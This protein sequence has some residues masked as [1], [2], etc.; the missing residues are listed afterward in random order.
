MPERTWFSMVIYADVLLFL[1]TVVTY[2]LL[3]SVCAVA[4]IHRRFWRLLL[5]SVAGGI[6]AFAVLLPDLGLF[7]VPFKFA[8]AAVIVLI[9]FSY[10]SAKRFFKLTALFFAVSFLYSGA[11]LC[12]WLLLKPD[13]MIINNTAVYL[14]ISPLLL[15]LLTTVCY[16]IIKLVCAL[17][18]KT[19]KEN[20]LFTVEVFAGGKSAQ[21]TA[22]LDTGNNLTDL[23]TG[24]P[25]IIAQESAVKAVFP[26]G[27][28][29]NAAGFRLLPYKAVGKSGV[30]PAF[31]PD[32]VKITG[33][34]GEKITEKMTVAVTDSKMDSE[35]KGLLCRS[36]CGIMEDEQ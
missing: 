31:R 11:M 23:Y 19:K 3:L 10:H 7:A 32:K 33:E 14:N 22:L 25:V 17:M 5:G 21:F 29:E 26:K 9:T 2:F 18:R 34:T 27:E 24:D 1:N 30:L 15:I 12:I 20:E 4:H 28:V 6:S 36:A 8:I 16:L 13:S 35:Y